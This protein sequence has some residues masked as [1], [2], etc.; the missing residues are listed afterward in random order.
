MK[1]SIVTATFNSAATLPDTLDSIGAQAYVPTEI[2]IQDGGS[3]DSTLEIANRYP[4]VHIESAR[5]G[6]LYDAMNR[7]VGRASGDIIGILNSDD[8]YAH[9]AVLRRVA[10]AFAADDGVDAVYGDLN[11]VDQHDTS[12]VVRSWRSG[13]NTK[14]GWRKGWM[15]PHPTFF[16]RRRVYEQ[17]GRFDTSFRFAADYE[18][19]LRCCYRYDIKTAYLP[20]VL[21]HMRAGGL[22]NSSLSNRLAANREDRRA[23]RVNQLDCPAALRFL[24][25]ARKLTQWWS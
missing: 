8:F 14:A 20:E 6:G 10:A 18:F 12:R 24:K 4:N 5:D 17:Y 22:S 1:I 21:V 3:K 9:E 25:P 15:P 23:W 13:P 7:G 16:V 2:I 11:Y 19:M